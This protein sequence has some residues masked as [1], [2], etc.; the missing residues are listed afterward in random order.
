MHTILS[1]LLLGGAWVA[2]AQTPLGTFQ[3]GD[4][5]WLDVEGEEQLSDTFTVGPGLLLTLPVIGDIALAG[6]AR[7]RIEPYLTQALGHYVRHPMVRA[8]ALVR[9]AITG[10]VTRPGFYAVPTD[11]VL[12]DAVMLAGGATPDARLDAMRVERGERRLLKA[13]AIARAVARGMSLDDLDLRAGDRIVVPRRSGG[14]EATAR[15]LGLLVT[16]PAA[17]YGVGRIF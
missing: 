16:I 4:R 8:R 7:S 17:I 5:V 11:L 2:A 13:G 12:A 6:V 1:L 9:I 14:F 10:Q 15:V 3:V